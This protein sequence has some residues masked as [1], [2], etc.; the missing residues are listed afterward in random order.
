VRSDDLGIDGFDLFV[1]QAQSEALASRLRARGAADVGMATAEVTRIEAGRPRFGVDMD[2]ETIPLEAGIQD[3]AISLTKGCYVG[4]EIIIRVLHRG[5]G[6]VAKRL[7]G[8]T[9]D[10][11]GEVARKGDAVSSG[12]RQ[13]GMVTSSARSP[14]LGRAVAMAYVHRDFTSAST[15]VTVT[16]AGGPQPAIVAS[17][18]LVPP[19]TRPVP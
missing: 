19:Q 13:I 5:Q 15:A 3:R 7:V 8:L 2:D 16:T 10:P 4:Q 14:A 18:P 6:R 1:P 12:D 17:L 11:S 9:F